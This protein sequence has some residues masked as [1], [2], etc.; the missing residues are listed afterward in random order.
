MPST[1]KRSF[2]K[3][4]FWEAVSFIFTTALVYLVYG[5]IETSLKF[6][7]VL[8]IIKIPFF[9]LHERLWKMIR[10]GKY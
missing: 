3:G 2:V 1:Y 4:V 10:W 9:F 5:N 8:T 7:L 6:S